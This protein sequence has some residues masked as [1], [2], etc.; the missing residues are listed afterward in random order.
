MCTVT[1]VP[2]VG[3]PAGVGDEGQDDR[4]LLAR[5][6]CSRDEQRSRPRAL[7]PV[8]R[9]IGARSAVM[10]ID[11]PSGGTWIAANDAGLVAC[12][13]NAN[14]CGGG[15]VG[16]G[17][18]ARSGE[19]RSRGGI[20]P[21]LMG[22]GSVAEA[23]A[24]TISLDASVFPAFRL[25]L[26]TAREHAVVVADGERVVSVQVATLRSPI[27]LTSSGLG[28]D[29]VGTPRSE[30]FAR[31]LGSGGAGG[32]GGDPLAAQAAF[33]EHFWPERRE[34]SVLMSREGARTVSHTIV[35]IFEHSVTCRYR[36]IEDAAS[37]PIPRAAGV[38]REA[39]EL[40]VHVRT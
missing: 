6:F 31:M 23:L 3:R 27:M 33:H 29:L 18:A 40:R 32:V 17:A 2:V 9:S 36:E 5:V 38:A 4:P 25:L 11:P 35:D 30:L 37:C 22:C 28:D 12:V 8:A 15:G 39:H 14:P 34:L 20:V 16:G 7:A 24:R 13:L 19:L 21:D 1:V 10:P 26:T